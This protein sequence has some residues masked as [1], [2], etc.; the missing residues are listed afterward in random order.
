MIKYEKSVFDNAI[1][2]ITFALDENAFEAG[3]GE[4]QKKSKLKSN[5]SQTGSFR[6]KINEFSS[7]VKCD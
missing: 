1:A 6:Q 4:K 2:K 5:M 7:F 3:E